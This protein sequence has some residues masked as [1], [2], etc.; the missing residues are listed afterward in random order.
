MSKVAAVILLSVAY[1]GGA[2]ASSYYKCEVNGK[3]VFSDVPCATQA[4]HHA[5]KLST[6]LG[7]PVT[8]SD[9]VERCSKAIK[10]RLKDPDSLKV[11]DVTGPIATSIVYEGTAI[12][13]YEFIFS[14]NAK[15]SYGGYVGNRMWVCYTSYDDSHRVLSVKNFEH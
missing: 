2:H 8:V 10:D 9:Q 3:K 7:S 14:I 4:E 11:G 15:N 5:I 6:P 1:I 13:A 12:M